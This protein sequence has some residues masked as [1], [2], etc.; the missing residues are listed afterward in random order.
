MGSRVGSRVG[1]VGVDRS[2][3]VRCAGGRGWGGVVVRS[4]TWVGWDVW[5]DGWVDGLWMDV[6]GECGCDAVWCGVA[7]FNAAGVW[8][9]AAY[10]VSSIT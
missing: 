2:V 8:V 3:G 6:G 9:A 1:G 7:A 4:G 5:W 10:P